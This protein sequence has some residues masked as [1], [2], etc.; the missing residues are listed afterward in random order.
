MKTIL[1]SLSGISKNF[2]LIAGIVCALAI[3][4]YSKLEASMNWEKLKSVLPAEST[5]VNTVSAEEVSWG[6]S[7][8]SS[9]VRKK[10]EL[11]RKG[12][13]VNS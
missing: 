8:L 2:L 7:S 11:N 3:L 6:E 13:S 4:S 10:I 9:L 5:Q 12:A 1:L